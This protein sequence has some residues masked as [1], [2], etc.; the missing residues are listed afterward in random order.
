[1]CL[2]VALCIPVFIE[3]ERER[4]RQSAPPILKDT[5]AGWERSRSLQSEFARR[6][7]ELGLNTLTKLF[8]GGWF[9]SSPDIFLAKLLCC[10]GILFQCTVIDHYIICVALLN[11]DKYVC[12]FVLLPFSFFSCCWKGC[13]AIPELLSV[14][15]HYN[16]EE[17]YPNF[18]QIKTILWKIIEINSTF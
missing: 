14:I 18:I 11:K 17:C 12:Y 2:S 7:L 1:M 5:G 4:E 13:L 9:F 6:V 16:S 8:P 15:N 3:R 10:F